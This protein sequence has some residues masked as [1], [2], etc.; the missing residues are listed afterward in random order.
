VRPVRRYFSCIHEKHLGLFTTATKRGYYHPF[1]ANKATHPPGVNPSSF[2]KEKVL[3][4]FLKISEPPLLSP[5]QW[6]ATIL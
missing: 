5:G 1:C 4:P 3:L 6:L 2:K